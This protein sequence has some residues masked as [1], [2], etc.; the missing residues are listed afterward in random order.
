MTKPWF[1]SD[2]DARRDA[3]HALRNRDPILA[4]LRQWLPERGLVLEIGSGTGQHV[5]WFAEHLPGLEWQPSDLD[6]G[7]RASIA[8]W[9]AHLSLANVR[10]P[11]AIDALEADWALDNEDLV[12]I[13]NMNMIHI[14]P[15]AVAQALLAG[16]GRMLDAGG[17]LYLYG[18][19]KR[20]G[21]HTSPSNAE[22]DA[23]LRGR[24][25]AWGIRDLEEVTAA[26]E[27]HGLALESTVEMPA[28]NLILIYR[29]QGRE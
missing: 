15:W 28:N 22:F 3:P 6:P 12:A 16:A 10:P 26:A 23:M 27:L 20:G 18:P 4:V 5:S 2:P 25:P 29:R 24:D 14:A 7:M 19:F 13:L 11:L 21:A 8:A 17:Q 9:T 1:A